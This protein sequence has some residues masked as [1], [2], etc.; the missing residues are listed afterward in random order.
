MLTHIR[1]RDFAIIEELDLEL[2]DGLTVVTGETGAGKSIMVDAIGLVLGDRADAGSVRH[3]AER[4][5]ITLTLETSSPAIHD[6]LAAHDIESDGQCLLRR[7]ITAEG[8]SRA[9]INGTPVTIGMLR[10]LGEQLVEISGQNTHQSLLQHPMQ[11]ELLDAQAGLENELAALEKI[12]MQIQADEQRLDA[13][14]TH[15]AE[16]QAKMDLLT[17]Q[18]QELSALALGE[19]ELEKLDQEQTQLAHAEQLLQTASEAI[20]R[21]YEADDAIHQQLSTIASRLRENTRLDARFQEPSELLESAMIQV[22]EAVESLR[23]TQD[24]IDIDPQRLAKTEARLSQAHSLARKH[25]VEPEQLYEKWQQLEAEL[26]ALQSPEQTPEELEKR[27][28]KQYA[29]YDK[30][31]ATISKKRKATAK[32]MNRAVTDA[33]QTLGMEGGR[34]E[35]RLTTL[36]ENERSKTGREQIDFLVSANPGQPL[37]PL[38][39]VASGGELSRISLAI[40]L[41]AAAHS[42]LPTLIFDEVDAGIGG[43]VAETVGKQLRTLGKH[44]Q[45]FCVTHLPQIAAQ[46]HQHFRVSKQKKKNH[47]STRMQALDQQAR[48]DEIA[49]MLGGQKITQQTLAHAEEMLQ[50][51]G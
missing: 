1:I 16:H 39:K 27:L 25:Q 26:A 41:I 13:L 32:E 8:R 35:I 20:S 40:Q 7:V 2:H 15:Q 37:K 12:W 10:E 5:E 36:P 24:S 17:F 51:T 9:T 6:W 18:L 14:Q 30:R 31:A 28:E 19:N 48:I 46:G 3:G 11:R 44:C 50:N 29:E 4:A 42:K 21:L 45:V 38:A 34:F 22:Q 43:A 23:S 49:R 47:T 33:M